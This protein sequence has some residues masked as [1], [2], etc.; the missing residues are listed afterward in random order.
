[1]PGDPDGETGAMSGMN[2][3]ASGCC[4]RSLPPSLKLP[5]GRELGGSK[6]EASTLQQL[7]RAGEGLHKAPTRQ[8]SLARP[9]L[10]G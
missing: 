1:M 8:R 3:M 10:R 6:G 4:S 5:H 7:L 9:H 2:K